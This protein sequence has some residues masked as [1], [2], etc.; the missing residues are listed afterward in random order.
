MGYAFG[1][2]APPETKTKFKEFEK[3][4]AIAFSEQE[5]QKLFI[6]RT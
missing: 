2:F 5:D 3:D 4:L 6:K 1:L